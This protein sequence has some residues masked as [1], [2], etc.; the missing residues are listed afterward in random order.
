MTPGN[1]WWKCYGCGEHGDAA[2][3][4]MRLRGV[5]F[6]EAV[7]WLAEQAGILPAAMGMPK[8]APEAPGRWPRARPSRSRQENPPACPWP[9]P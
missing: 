8:T 5:A 1:P 9:M 7:R 6:P 3:L 4:V 2:T